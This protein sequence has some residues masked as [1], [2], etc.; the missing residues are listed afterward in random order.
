MSYR[1]Y[2]NNYQCLG[3]NEYSKDLMEELKKQRL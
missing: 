1:T 2:V 3:N